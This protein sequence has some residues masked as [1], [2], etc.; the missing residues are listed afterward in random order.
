VALWTIRQARGQKKDN[1]LT[2]SAS[3]TGH[4]QKTS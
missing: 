3:N 4:L 2:C 1:L